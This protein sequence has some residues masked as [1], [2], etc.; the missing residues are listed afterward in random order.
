MSSHSPSVMTRATFASSVVGGQTGCQT[1]W[2]VACTALGAARW[3][4]STGSRLER[5]CKA[6]PT[7]RTQTKHGRQPLLSPPNL[8]PSSPLLIAASPLP[9]PSPPPHRPPPHRPLPLQSP[10]HRRQG[11]G[12]GGLWQHRPPPDRRLPHLRDRSARTKLPGDR[13]QLDG[14]VRQPGGD[15]AA[16]ARVAHR[17][18]RRANRA[19]QRWLNDLRWGR[20]GRG[21][22]LG[23]RRCGVG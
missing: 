14:P 6:G 1:R 16:V 7:L 10:P 2:S 22:R 9:S 11:G 15:E 20:P 18:Y 17:R 5:P 19:L 4:E 21:M 13:P 23:G 12:H 8:P 3:A